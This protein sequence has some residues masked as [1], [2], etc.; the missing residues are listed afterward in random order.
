[1]SKF[2]KNTKSAAGF[3]LVELMVVVA[4][5]GILASIAIPQYSKY[6]A[7]ARTSEAKVSLAAIHAAQT[8]FAIESS[9]FTA[10]LGAIGWQPHNYAADPTITQKFYYATGFPVA[11]G[12][13][14]QCGQGAQACL[15]TSWDPNPATAAATATCAEATLGMTA[16]Q[17]TQVAISGDIPAATDVRSDTLATVQ[18]ALNAAGA[19]TAAAQLTRVA[20]DIRAAG[21]VRGAPT[22][23][24]PAAADL[25]IW[26]INQNKQVDNIQPA[27]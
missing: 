3:T 8:S 1:M 6:Q 22:G 18:G 2:L 21:F 23:A 11:I 9:S 5:I 12:A 7:R 24:A 13:T 20:F 15:G 19:T 25:D 17:A 26:R 14:A 27:L 16:F 10:C 4:I